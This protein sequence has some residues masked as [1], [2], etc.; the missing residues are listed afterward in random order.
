MP[1]G[2]LR[3][4]VGAPYSSVGAF[5]GNL[6]DFYNNRYILLPFH[7]VSHSIISHI[8]IDT[9]ESRHMMLMN[10]D[11]CLDSLASIWMWEMIEWFTLWNGEKRR[12]Y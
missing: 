10:L 5:V 8:H 4:F 2:G 1:R 6:M 12:E 9:N 7:N 3:M 11:I